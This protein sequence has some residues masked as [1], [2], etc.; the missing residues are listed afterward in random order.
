MSVLPCL[1]S[2]DSRIALEAYPKLVTGLLKEK[3]YKSDS[4]QDW[5]SP[6]REARVR[7]LKALGDGRIRVRYGFDVQFTSKSDEERVVEDG[8]GDLLDAVLGA[9]QAAWAS[10][11]PNFGIPNDCDSLEGWIVDPIIAE[12]RSLS[13]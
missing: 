6:Q 7:I 4:R 10:R 5:L 8:S 1:P 12:R 11:Q 13:G 2:D 9:I 3:D